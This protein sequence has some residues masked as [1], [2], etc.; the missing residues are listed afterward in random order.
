MTTAPGTAGW[1]AP[2]GTPRW[3]SSAPGSPGRYYDKIHAVPFGEYIPLRS[4]LAP[5][6]PALAQI[7]SDMVP[8]TR[9]GLLDVPVC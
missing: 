7:P 1:K 3:S 5:R 9:A 4:L 2:P 8:G 6:V